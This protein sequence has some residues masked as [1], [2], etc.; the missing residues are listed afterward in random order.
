MYMKLRVCSPSPLAAD[1][2][3][4][5]LAAAGPGPVRAVDVVVAGHARD[6]AE[7]LAVVAA[8][9]LAEELLPPVAVLRHRRVGVLLLQRLDVRRRLLVGRVHAGGGGE[10]ESLD[11]ARLLRR[12]KEVG[13]DQHREHAE[14]LVVLDESH[15]AHVGREVVDVLRALDG[16]DARVVELEVE[17]AVVRL[18]GHLVPLLDRAHV[19]RADVGVAV[20]EEGGD[21]VR[22]DEAATTPDE[23]EVVWLAKQGKVGR[24][25]RA[26]DRDRARSR[27]R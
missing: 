26:K 24:V 2:R 25:H 7:V 3:R 22:A 18:V 17:D 5:L 21:E 4:R 16:L 15:A 13:V 1:R 9:A 23:D 11:A 6:E 19:H 8:H 12:A 14:R 10:E 27:C 20:R